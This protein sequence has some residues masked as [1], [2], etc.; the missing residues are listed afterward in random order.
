MKLFIFSIAP[1]GAFYLGSPNNDHLNKNISGNN[2]T[3]LEECDGVSECSF[4]P[5]YTGKIFINNPIL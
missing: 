4:K 3:I 5:D 1:V 2:S